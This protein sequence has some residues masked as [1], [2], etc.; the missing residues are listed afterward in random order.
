MEP[1]KHGKSLMGFPHTLLSR[2][3]I[4]ISPRERLILRLV[5]K[6]F[7]KIVSISWSLQLLQISN[8]IKSYHQSIDAYPPKQVIAC[9]VLFQSYLSLKQKVTLYPQIILSSPQCNSCAEY[10]QIII[11][12]GL[13]LG[14]EENDVNFQNQNGLTEFSTVV[15]LLKAGFDPLTMFCRDNPKKGRKMLRNLSVFEPLYTK[16]KEINDIFLLCCFIANA[17][18]VS[19]KLS[20]MP[21]LTLFE[22]KHTEENLFSILNSIYVNH[23]AKYNP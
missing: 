16:C 22:R 20:S 3:F 5:S 18:R 1:A 7:N 17:H 15:N 10:K 11:C 4:F 12:L 2:I 6:E 14:L 23:L 9:K 8:T 19:K 13:L 21:M